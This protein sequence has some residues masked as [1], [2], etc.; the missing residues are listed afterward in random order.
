MT[1]SSRDIRPFIWLNEAQTF[2]RSLHIW[3]EGEELNMGTQ[4]SV[5]LFCTERT[6]LFIVG[7][8][9]TSHYVLT[10]SLPTLFLFS[11]S[12]GLDNTYNGLLTWSSFC[13]TCP[14]S[15]SSTQNMPNFCPEVWYCNGHCIKCAPKQL[16]WFPSMCAEYNSRSYDTLASRTRLPRFSETSWAKFRAGKILAINLI[17]PNYYVTKHVSSP[18]HKSSGK[19]CNGALLFHGILNKPRWPF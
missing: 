1:D 6:D 8:I 15:R 16:S 13:E 3:A 2:P 17:T 12:K 11:L 18:L 9:E 19:T 10:S 7:F 4:F 5:F 14:S